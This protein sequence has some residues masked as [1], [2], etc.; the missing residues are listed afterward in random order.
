MKELA[1]P[2]AGA[3]SA[4]I[5][6]SHSAG[7]MLA[8]AVL[9]ASM[10]FVD[11]TIVNISIPSI[12][13][14]FAG[15]RLSG[16]SWVLNAYNVVFA[17]F[18]VGGGQLADVLGR[19]RVFMSALVLFTLASLLCAL[20]PSLAVLIIARVVQA[21][22]AAMLIPSSLAIVL[23][24]RPVAERAHAVS[25]WA[26]AA[27][28]AA[29]IGPPLGGVLITISS[30][31][32]VFLV[33]LPVGVLALVLAR[34][35]L[36][37]SRSPGDGRLPDLLG[38]VVLAA[39]IASLVLAIV[40]GPEWG[41]TSARVLGAFLAS[42]LLGGCFAVRTRTRPTALIDLSL[43]RIRAFAASNATT[44]VMATGFYAYTLCNVLFLTEVWRYSILQA[45]LALT[46]GPV[47]AMVVA[48]AAGRVIGRVGH[49]PISVVG[50]LVW[51]GGM[52]YFAS[53]LGADPD[54]LGQWLPGIVVLGVGAGLAFPSVT[55]V[56]VLVVPGH[57]YALASALNSVA[58]QL[59][60]ALGVALLVAI[61][62]NPSPANALHAFRS[63]WVFA[64]CCF[65][66]GACGCAALKVRSHVTT[67]AEPIPAVE[68]T[69]PAGVAEGAQI[70]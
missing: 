3:E 64:A 69:E 57:R 52:V 51:A 1:R 11:L 29:G 48:G 18:L 38:E 70:I 6:R 41:W 43:L 17:A 40:N 7:A 61:V 9:G 24:V 13:R 55:G 46:P 53:S 56:A 26:A 27:A 62:G 21:G 60:A 34:R 47:T 45:G 66:V 36:S 67:E 8:V 59:G 49:R 44:L 63:G 10:A 30:W 42:L 20:A 15:S 32:L 25:L 50:A 4:G 33:N 68:R 31:R 35:V 22:G 2:G 16:V 28:A 37:E 39:A 12:A 58:R 23:H 19:R 5:G 65:L 54:F 14:S